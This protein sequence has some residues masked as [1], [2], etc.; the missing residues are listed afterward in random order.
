MKQQNLPTKMLLL[1]ALVV[2]SVS[3]VWADV[4]V[5]SEDFENQSGLPT[6]WSSDSKGGGSTAGASQLYTGTDAHGEGSGKQQG[7]AWKLGTN[8]NPYGSVTTC[9]LT[10][11]SG[12]ATLTFWAR[13]KSEKSPVIE[14]SGTNCTITGDGVSTTT[15][16]TVATGTIAGSNYTKY[17]VNISSGSSITTITFRHAGPSNAGSYIY[18][19]DIEISMP[20]EKVDPTITFNNG[21][22]NVGKNLDLSTLFTSNSTGS[23]TYSIIEGNG[24]A[25]I[26]G[27][28]LTGTAEGTV[29]IKAEQDETGSYKEGEATATITVNPALTLSSIAVTTAPT[30]TTY[31]EGETFNPT[32]MVVTATYNDKST[33]NVTSLCSFSPATALTTSNTE[34]TISYTEGGVTKTASCNITVVEYVQPMEVTM[35]LNNAFFGTEFTGSNAKGSGSHTAKSNGITVNFM[36]GGEKNNFYISD[37]EIRAYSGNT[38]EFVA[39]TGYVITK[40]VF[41]DAWAT[42][43]TCNPSGLD[44]N[45]KTWKG[46]SNSVAFTPTSKSTITQLTVTLS[47]QPATITLASACTDGTNYFGTYSNESAFVVPSDLTVSAVSVSGGKLTVTDYATGDIVKAGTGVMVSSATAGDHTVLLSSEIGTEISGNMLKGSGAGITAEEMSAENT[48][49]YRL[50]MHNGETIG[51]WWG[52]ENGAAFSLAANKAY[53]AVPESASAPALGFEFGGDTTGISQHLT[54]N[55]Q[56]Q[57]YYDLSGRRVAQPTKGLYI[58]N[59]KKVL[60]K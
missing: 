42:G 44:N 18:I 12:N 17:T 30:K 59:G 57:T 13:G 24:Y 1:F 55:T 60:V 43:T 54:P 31:S 22:V 45:R 16:G 29:K 34:I 21:S 25:T 11:L 36:S 35:T 2:G 48:T 50:T 15:S 41:T 10:S 32:G 37:S 47:K 38:L 53:L 46:V 3:S 56:Q 6:N 20:A 52:A 7:K 14:I 19:D 9:A 33:E 49:F 4:I 58:L 5:L 28:I 39:P 51:F 27:N 40:I 8:S 23:V 26:E